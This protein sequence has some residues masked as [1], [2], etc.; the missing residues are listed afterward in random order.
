MSDDKATP[1]RF[2]TPA[3]LAVEAE[4]AATRHQLATTV[5]ELTARLAPRA[6]AEAAVATA[7]RLASDATSPDAD[8]EDRARARRVLVGVGAGVAFV[9]AIVVLRIARR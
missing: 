4:I 1:E 9:T 5:D 3:M 2:T 7:R 8:P 6:Q